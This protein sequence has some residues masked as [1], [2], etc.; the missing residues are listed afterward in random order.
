MPLI[1][2]P[3]ETSWGGH[4]VRTPRHGGTHGSVA[5][6]FQ[7]VGSKLYPSGPLLAAVVAT[8][9]GVLEA[10]WFCQALTSPGSRE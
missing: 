6:F 8:L 2:A 5:V 4:G 7:K 1:R 9:E 3:G 10:G